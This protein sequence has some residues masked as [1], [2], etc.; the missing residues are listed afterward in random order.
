MF[1]SVN[2]DNQNPDR[3]L[4]AHRAAASESHSDLQIYLFF[5]QSL[6]HRRMRKYPLIPPLTSNYGLWKGF[7]YKSPGSLKPRKR[8]LPE[9]WPPPPGESR[10]DSVNPEYKLCGGH[11]LRRCHVPQ[12][13]V[14]QGKN[15]SHRI[16]QL[17]TLYSEKKPM[18]LCEQMWVWQLMQ[19]REV[20]S[21]AVSGHASGSQ[22]K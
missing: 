5:L 12:W 3:V 6:S 2:D 14:T 21:L 7:P 8:N 4:V 13:T 18:N 22:G 17:S 9:N 15:S 11:V 10:S 19:S 1:C 20:Q 16:P